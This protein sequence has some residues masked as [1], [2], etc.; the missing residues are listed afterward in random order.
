MSVS[1]RERGVTRRA[2]LVWSV[3]VT[4]FTLTVMHRTTLGVAG[5]DASDRLGISP[6]VLSAVM[7]SQTVVFLVLH[8]P[9][10]M[11]V[12]RWG[13]RAC[14]ALG[15]L[16]V[17]CGQLGVALTRDLG[18]LIA[19][20]MLIGVADSVVLVATLALVP[21]WFPARRVPLMTQLTALSGQARQVLSAVP[22]LA[23]LDLGG[24]TAAFSSAAATSA[25]CAVLVVVIVRDR[26]QAAGPTTSN[27]PSPQRLGAQLRTVWSRAGTRLGFF[28][29]MATQF[30]MMVFALLWGVPYL[31][32]G[33]GLSA[34]RAGALFSLMAVATFAVAPLM[35]IAQ[36]RHPLRRSALA[37]AVIALTMITWTV[38]L[39][40][41]PPAPLWLLVVLALV[42]S[43]GGPASVIGFD[44]ARTSNPPHQLGLAQSMVN[45]GGFT[46]TL[47]VVILMGV[48]LDLAGGYTEHGFRLAWL[49]MYPFWLLA[50]AGLLLNR[51]KVR[52][53][54][55]S[56]WPVTPSPGDA[57][58]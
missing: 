51:R 42:L 18:V 3:G 36:Q 49:A 22:F 10:G 20:R 57:I 23:L 47:T 48:V 28:T 2:Y 52:A 37:L 38:V 9:S 27:Q 55:S 43:L 34:G 40:V 41:P 17:A 45:T 6:A 58:G 8:I 26:P 19:G 46:A 1:S 44:L 33:Q 30:P 31:T 39:L 15:A 7:L 56:E 4:A 11:L 50:T 24:W 16:L 21:R 35:G 29:H 54:R 14:L 13:S 32:A 25:L 53:D 12:D 5:I